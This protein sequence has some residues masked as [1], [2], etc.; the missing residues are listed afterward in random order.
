MEDWARRW[1]W[2]SVGLIV[3]AWVGAAVISFVVAESQSSDDAALPESV[4]AIESTVEWVT[5]QANL[6]HGI[7][8]GR[9]L[10]S[11]ERIRIRNECEITSDAWILCTDEEI[12]KLS[13][14][15]LSEFT[16]SDAAQLAELCRERVAEVVGP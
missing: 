8:A 15:E 13:E 6:T 11:E 10:R 5:C 1:L 4:V 7:A 16:S 2:P 9:S 3:V 14:P 12:S